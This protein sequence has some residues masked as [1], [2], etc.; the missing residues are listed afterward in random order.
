MC[1]YI[2]ECSLSHTLSYERWRKHWE[3]RKEVNAL[4]WWGVRGKVAVVAE[5][6]F[7]I[8]YPVKYFSL[9]DVGIGNTFF[10]EVYKIAVNALLII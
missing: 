6:L 9:R 10:A 5:W 3:G 1:R 7:I 4:L 2:N 8:L